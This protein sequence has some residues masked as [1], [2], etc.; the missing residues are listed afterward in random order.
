MRAETQKCVIWH[1]DTS[2][3]LENKKLQKIITLNPWKY[4]AII[5]IERRKA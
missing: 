1:R 4:S 3:Y 2:N 5:N